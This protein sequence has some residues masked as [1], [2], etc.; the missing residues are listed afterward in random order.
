MRATRK[1]APSPWLG[2]AT[3]PVDASSLA[4]ARIVVGAAGVLSAGRIAANGWIDSLYAGPS[5]R[6]TYLGFGW[7]PQPGP[8]AV[9]AIVAVLAAASMAVALGWRTRAA[10]VVLVGAFAW[11]ELIDATTYLN[12]YWFLTLVGIL[13][14]VVPWGAALS[15]DARRAGGPTTVARGWVW[16][17]R[18]QVGIVYTFAGLAK[19]QH[20]W[21]VDALPLRLWLPART[22]VPI[23]GPFMGLAVTPHAFAIAGAAFDCLIVPALLW[24][25]TRGPAWVVLVVFHVCTWALF[26]IGVFPWLMI[27]A[28]TVFFAPD[29]PRR[30]LARTGRSVAV[31]RVRPVRRS[32]W[33]L[34][35][36]VVWVA[37]QLALPLRHLAASGDPRWTG[38]GYRFAWNVLLVE[39]SGSV[40]FL[41]HDRATGRDWVAD[42]SLLYNENQLRVMAPEPDLIH[43]A[44]LAIAADEWSRGHDVEV[45]VDAWASLN[46]RPAQRLIDPTVDL[47]HTP[48]DLAPDD[49]ILPEHP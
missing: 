41:V 38:Q 19:L 44:A 23:L 20:D 8:G 45:R 21:L 42:P 1:P 35:L 28:S 14:V 22:A 39:K 9:Q 17:L 43:Q 25:R 34:G 48:R 36:A 33:W 29:W 7:V 47:A 37:V 6:F 5:H 31:P 4:V 16:L 2:A 10:C 11:I 32:S 40:T 27:G 49:W 26:P 46:G 30:V 13:G 15:L 18:F 12:H 3:T 24:R